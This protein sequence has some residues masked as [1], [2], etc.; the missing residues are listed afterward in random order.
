[1]PQSRQVHLGPVAADDAVRPQAAAVMMRSALTVV[2]GTLAF[3]LLLCT[4]L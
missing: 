3:L 1:M 2:P 4:A